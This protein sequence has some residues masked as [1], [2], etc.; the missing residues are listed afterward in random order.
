MFNRGFKFLRPLLYF[1]TLYHVFPGSCRGDDTDIKGRLLEIRKRVGSAIGEDFEISHISPEYQYV[2]GEPWENYIQSIPVILHHRVGRW[3]EFG[4]FAG[5][6]FN[7][8]ACAT[9]TKMHYM[10]VNTE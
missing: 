1:V 5:I 6:Y 10:A 3:A 7:A 2:Q 9:V 8:I 4:T